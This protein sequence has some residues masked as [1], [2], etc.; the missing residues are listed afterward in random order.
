MFFSI[1]RLD[2]Q[3][4]KKYEKKE[5]TNLFRVQYYLPLHLFYNIKL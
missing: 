1:F 5:A 2:C 3:W 4:D